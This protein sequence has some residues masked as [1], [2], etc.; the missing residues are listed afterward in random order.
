MSYI[1][2]YHMSSNT[3]LGSHNIV[4]YVEGDEQLK[5]SLHNLANSFG[6]DLEDK[7]SL[8]DFNGRADIY[9]S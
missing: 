4:I 1:I 2:T 5:Q 9:M 8:E 6:Y 7:D 3:P